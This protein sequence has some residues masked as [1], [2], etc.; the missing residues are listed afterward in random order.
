[1]STETKLP[2]RIDLIVPCSIKIKMNFVET[3]IKTDF[4]LLMIIV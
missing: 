2:L 4:F 1:M 3:K